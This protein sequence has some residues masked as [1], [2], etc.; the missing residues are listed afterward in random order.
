MPMS[1]D[2]SKLRIGIIIVSVFCFKSGGRKPAISVELRNSDVNE[3]FVL[4]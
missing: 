3:I 4:V 2:I 1:S